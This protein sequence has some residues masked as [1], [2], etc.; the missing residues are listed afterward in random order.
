MIYIESGLIAFLKI[1][2]SASSLEGKRGEHFEKKERKNI[3]HKRGYNSV[4]CLPSSLAGHQIQ[5]YKQ[6][7]KPVRF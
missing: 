3:Y 1:Y 5:S 6:G 4:L 7:E 2:L